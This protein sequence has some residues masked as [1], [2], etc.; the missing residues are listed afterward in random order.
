MDLNE[1]SKQIH[2]QNVKASWWEPREGEDPCLFEKLVLVCSEISE[3]LEGFRK[4][5]M[6]D[7]LKDRSMLEVE[8]AD[9]LIRTLDLGGYAGWVLKSYPEETVHSFCSNKS[10]LQKQLLGLMC[11]A[12][13]LAEDLDYFKGNSPVLNHD[14]NTLVNS[15]LLVAKNNCLNI[16]TAAQ[17]K[18]EYNKNRPDH[19]KENRESGKPGSKA[20]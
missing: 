6:D 17:E 4:N 9:T 3:G 16:F 19:K 2:A 18:L 8:L 11:A 13:S 7:H 12:C 10:S 15:I 14:Y 20:F 5:L 1:F